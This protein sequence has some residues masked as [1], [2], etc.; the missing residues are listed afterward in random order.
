MQTLYSNINNLTKFLCICCITL[1]LPL[2]QKN[3]Y[4]IHTHIY[5]YTVHIHN[6]NLYIYYKI[7]SLFSVHLRINLMTL[8]TYE[9]LGIN[10]LTFFFSRKYVVSQYQSK[11]ES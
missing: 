2:L 1:Y 10:R 4:Y 5:T 7:L 9:Q 8:K 11:N 6:L 3:I